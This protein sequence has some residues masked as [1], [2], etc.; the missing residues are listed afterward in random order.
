[1]YAASGKYC[2]IVV[3][4]VCT[5]PV[6][7][8]AIEPYDTNCI[9]ITEDNKCSFLTN[10]TQ[11]FNALVRKGIDDSVYN[12]IYKLND[13][14]SEINSKLGPDG[15]NSIKNS[16][17]RIAIDCFKILDEDKT[18]SECVN[19]FNPEYKGCHHIIANDYQILPNGDV[20]ILEL[21]QGPGFKNIRYQTQQEFERVW[22]ELFQITIDKQIESKDYDISNIRFWK[23]I[24]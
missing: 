24:Y 13:L 9:D 16:M 17:D 11:G 7:Y 20:K 1:M 8:F 19:K 4:F 22:D 14:K 15:L 5:V 2:R 18:L 10:I 6:I 23:K 3:I 21:N 12:Y